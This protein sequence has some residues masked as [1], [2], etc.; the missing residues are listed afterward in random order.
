M[1]EQKS[2]NANGEPNPLEH[3]TRWFRFVRDPSN[4]NAVIAIFTVFI[5]LSRSCKSEITLCVFSIVRLPT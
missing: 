1:A 2:E 5:F 4:S 3:I